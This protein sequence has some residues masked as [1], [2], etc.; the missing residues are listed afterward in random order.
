MTE[1]MRQSSQ[2][3]S[4]SGCDYS[5]NARRRLRNIVWKKSYPQIRMLCSVC[6]ARVFVL[7]RKVCLED[8]V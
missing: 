5:K 1:R 3:R 2:T 8:V 4:E 6:V 7:D